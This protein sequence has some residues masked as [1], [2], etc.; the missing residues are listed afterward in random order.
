VVEHTARNR[1]I[2]GLYPATDTW[3]RERENGATITSHFIKGCKIY[4]FSLMNIF[5]CKIK[6]EF[7]VVE[8]R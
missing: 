7:E 3:I 1:K 4:F 8:R 5:L 2:K 6:I